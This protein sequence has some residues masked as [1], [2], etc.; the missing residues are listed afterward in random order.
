VERHPCDVIQKKNAENH[1]EQA[2]VVFFLINCPVLKNPSNPKIPPN[3]SPDLS[4]DRQMKTASSH[5][6]VRHKR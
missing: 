3:P 6:G 4:A 1:F 5:G 2:E